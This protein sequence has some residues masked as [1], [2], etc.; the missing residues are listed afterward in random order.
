[1]REGV[2]SVITRPITDQVFKHVSHIKIGMGRHLSLVLI[3]LSMANLSEFDRRFMEAM[4][5]CTL[6]LS[7]LLLIL[8]ECTRLGWTNIH[9]VLEMMLRHVN[10]LHLDIATFE[11][12]GRP[13]SMTILLTRLLVARHL[14]W[15]PVEKMDMR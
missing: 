4:K 14:A 15:C 12:T 2:T 5:S 11:R 6:A 8:M 7:G 3:Q 1:M 13:R 10:C 9:Q